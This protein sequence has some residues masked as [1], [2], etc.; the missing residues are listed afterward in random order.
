MSKK[1]VIT[2]KPCRFI[3]FEW[4]RYD[5]N[6]NGIYTAFFLAH[7]T[8]PQRFNYWGASEH[9]NTLERTKPLTN[10]EVSFEWRYGK[11]WL[12]ELKPIEQ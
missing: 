10:F 6:G 9:R 12:L 4:E 3:A 2:W 7:D 11:K 1:E 5:K 8:T